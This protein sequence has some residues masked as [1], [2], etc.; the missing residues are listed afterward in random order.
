MKKKKTFFH[1]NIDILIKAHGTN[2]TR[3][4]REVGILG[5]SIKKWTEGGET[6][7]YNMTI[8]SDYFKIPIDVLIR[9]EIKE[10]EVPKLGEPWKQPINERSAKLNEKIAD[11]ILEKDKMQCDLK[12]FIEAIDRVF[13]F[14]EKDLD[15]HEFKS[16]KEEYLLIRSRVI[17]TYGK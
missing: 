4:G 9:H 15:P 13:N 7:F 10:E 11:M 14:L 3:L 1:Q 6:D 17:S 12:E 5:S 16:T 2:P 8:I